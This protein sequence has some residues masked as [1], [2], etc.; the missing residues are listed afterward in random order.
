[1]WVRATMVMVFCSKSCRLGGMYT[2]LWLIY[3][4]FNSLMCV[5]GDGYNMGWKNTR[6]WKP[7]ARGGDVK[8]WDV[9]PQLL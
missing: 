4:N 8:S 5:R 7:M 3:V 6:G 2:M 9:E 1:M